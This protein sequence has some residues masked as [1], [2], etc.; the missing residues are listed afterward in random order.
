M[1]GVT[2]VKIAKLN[3][4]KKSPEKFRAF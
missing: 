3:D 4:N 1:S 2:I